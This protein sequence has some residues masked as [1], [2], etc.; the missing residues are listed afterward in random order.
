MLLQVSVCLAFVIPATGHANNAAGSL[1]GHHRGLQGT[2]VNRGPGG[3]SNNRGLNR[4]QQQ[5]STRQDQSRTQQQGNFKQVHG[6]R[7]NNY[8][9]GQGNFTSGEKQIQIKTQKLQGYLTQNKVQGYVNSQ[10]LH[11]NFHQAEN[12]KHQEQLGQRKEYGHNVNYSLSNSDRKLSKSTRQHVVS[13]KNNYNKQFLTTRQ[14]NDDKHK[15][16]NKHHWQHGHCKYFSY[17]PFIFFSYYLYSYPYVYY[18]PVYSYNSPAYS[19]ANYSPSGNSYEK[20]IYSTSN[21]F[22]IDSAGWT[23]LAQGELQTALDIFAKDAEYFPNAG[24]P[25]VGYA[26]AAAAAGDLT[27]GVIAMRE[28]FHIDPD[29]I[30]YLQF[31][32]KVLAIIN[33]LIDIFE[34]SLQ[35]NA[36]QPDEAFMLSALNYLKHDYGSAHEAIG[37]AI[38]DGDNSPSVYNLHVL[39]DEELTDEYAGEYN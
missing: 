16:H 31:D 15:K 34:D 10:K 3:I 19:S 8:H 29:S 12:K 1:S 28:A 17:Y 6:Q 4:T 24:I 30:H 23:V 38:M 26:I 27:Q 39:I 9:A 37:R 36:K 2:S 11:G 22:G 5:I 25:K 32:D 18:S 13:G 21:L 14:Q 35:E 20:N 7:Q 33:D